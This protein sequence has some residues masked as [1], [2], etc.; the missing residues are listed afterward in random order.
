MSLISELEHQ[1]VDDILLVRVDHKRHALL[2]RQQA[3][4]HDHIAEVALTRTTVR[5]ILLLLL[6]I[7][8]PHENGIDVEGIVHETQLSEISGL[9]GSLTTIFKWPEKLSEFDC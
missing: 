7:D 4:D 8:G 6:L 9:S 1:E 3:A 5:E 2:H